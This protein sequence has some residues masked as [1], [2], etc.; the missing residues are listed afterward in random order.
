M[1]A[2]KPPCPCDFE[3]CLG[4]AE[5]GGAVRAY[6]QTGLD[7][8]R[9]CDI[10]TEDV[11]ATETADA[12]GLISEGA[13]L[14]VKD[15]IGWTPLHN[16][17]YNG[18]VVLVQA[19]LEKDADLHAKDKFGQTSL[20]IACMNGHVEVAMALL[21]KGADLHAKN[22]GGQTSLH[23]AYLNGHHDIAAMLREHRGLA[24]V[25]CGARSS[26]RTRAT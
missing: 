16:A 2:Q 12:V 17:C 15:K 8:L 21:E 4:L 14:H 25:T 3:A 1:R 18:R 13:D 20:H 9:M 11:T 19:L 10:S 7:L 24:K 6:L 5:E 22:S 23:W 26:G